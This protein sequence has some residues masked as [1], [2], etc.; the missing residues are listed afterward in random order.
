MAEKKVGQINIMAKDINGNASGGI[1]DDAKTIKNE[2]G[3]N[4][5]Q[6]G[7]KGGVVHDKNEDRKP[8]ENPLDLKV[9]KV[10][11]EDKKIELNKSHKFIATEFNREAAGVELDLVKWAYQFDDGKMEYCELPGKGVAGKT[12][13]TKDIY[14]GKVGTATKVRVYAFVKT[15]SKE[16][17]VEVE[18]ITMPKIL[19]VNGHWNR[20]A[21]MLGMSP[22]KGGEKYW[23][24][25]TGNLK[26]Y[27]KEAESYFG[28]TESIVKYSDGSSAWG[29]SESG[30]ERKSRGYK[31]GKDNFDD[32]INGLGKNKVYLVSHSEGGALAAGVAKYL[33]EK[34]IEIGESLMLSTDE[35]DEF[36][37]EG[38][39]P[40]YQIVAG[41]L[42][43]VYI[44]NKKL[45][46]IDPVVQDNKVEGITR[47]G[48]FITNGSF[49]TVHGATIDKS[50][51]AHAKTLKKIS[52]GQ[53]WNSKGNIVYQTTPMDDNWY[54]VDDTTLYNKRVDLYPQKNSNVIGLATERQD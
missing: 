3:G 24:Y 16:A 2:T 25:F 41:Y 37:V 19:F 48:I 45:F 40:A 26:S 7:G 28:I 36:T 47:Y 43:N 10:T 33:S 6:S 32:I 52:I 22:G 54:K 1:R 53:A 44:A 20:I 11:S 31:Y 51:F 8:V 34:G 21:N 23:Q 49:A 14:I 38:N 17:S 9:I 18:I 35:G 30:S 39:Y 46:N 29:G 27:I 42:S 5:Y 15:P 50:F 4:F 13:V 12:Q